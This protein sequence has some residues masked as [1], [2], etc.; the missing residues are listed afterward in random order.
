[1]SKKLSLATLGIVSSTL[2]GCSNQIESI[3]PVQ[4]NQSQQVSAQSNLGLSN[5]M[6]NITEVVFMYLD[7]DRDGFL[8]LKEYISGPNSN[9]EET[10]AAFKKLDKDNDGKISLE[11]A[12]LSP[13]VFLP[14]S[15]FSK[16]SLRAYVQKEFERNDMDKNGTINDVE[17]FNTSI[18]QFEYFLD[19]TQD[20]KKVA[21]GT[22]MFEASDRNHD[23]KLSFSEF[24][25]FYYNMMTGIMKGS[26][27]GSA[28][29]PTPIEPP[30][31]K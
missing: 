12:K 8:T 28:V 7:K 14:K 17:F 26:L 25:D 19:A 4:Q 22:F 11:D 10:Q 23:K 21:I 16:E 13:K 1:M 30:P 24:E 5:T 31:A 29:T 18:K 20:F 6:K 9:S 2:I 15:T 27:L 3:Q